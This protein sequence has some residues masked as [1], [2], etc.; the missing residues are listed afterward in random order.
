MHYYRQYGVIKTKR[1]SLINM[2]AIIGW[3]VALPVTLYVLI[4]IKAIYL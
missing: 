2:L 1:I 3:F 4:K